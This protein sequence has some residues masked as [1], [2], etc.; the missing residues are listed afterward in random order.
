MED[1]KEQIMDRWRKSM[2]LLSVKNDLMVYDQWAYFEEFPQT[3]LGYFRKFAYF[4]ICISD[5]L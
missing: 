3:Q 2:L 5:L 4:K 1:L